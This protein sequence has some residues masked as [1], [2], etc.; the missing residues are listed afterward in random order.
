LRAE[1]ARN[2]IEYESIKNKATDKYTLQ[3]KSN[4]ENL[5]MKIYAQHMM[6]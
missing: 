4:L 1:Y 3:V 5:A 6:L 2:H